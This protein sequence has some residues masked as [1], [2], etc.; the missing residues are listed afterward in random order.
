MTSAAV[1]EAHQRMM[2][3]MLCA[4]DKVCRR[5]HIPYLLFA[6]TALGAVRHQGFIP[7]DDDLDLIMLRPDYERFL[8]VAPS[9]LDGETYYLQREFSPHWPMCFS[10]LRRNGTACIERYIPKDPETHLGVYI[11][12]FPCDNLSDRRMIRGLQ[13]VASKIVIAKGLDRRGYLTDR[14]WKK[15]FLALCR[16]L[17]DRALLRFAQRRQEPDSEL[18]HCFFGGASRYGKSVF[19]RQRLREAVLLPFETGRFPVSAYY[20][21][22]LTALYGAYQIPTPVSQRGCKVHAELVDLSHSYEAYIG[23]QETMQFQELSRSVR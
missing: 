14:W 15:L 18:V 19:P 11:D 4:V 13:F 12:L 1:H 6:G 16:P 10:K 7:W 5:N 8:A 17:P 3:E 2:L 21:G 9:E 23:V 20:D 22:L